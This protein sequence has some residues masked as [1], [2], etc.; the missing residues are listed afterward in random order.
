[1]DIAPCSLQ[2]SLLASHHVM[3]ILDTATCACRSARATLTPSQ[4]LRV[5]SALS[6]A[7]LLQLLAVRYV[8]AKDANYGCRLLAVQLMAELLAVLCN[9][10]LVGEQV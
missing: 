9:A 4:A 6:P 7:P 8:A 3:C 5:V 1:M 2:V 10:L